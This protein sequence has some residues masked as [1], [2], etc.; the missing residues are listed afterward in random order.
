[1]S[2]RNSLVEILVVEIPVVEIPVV[3]ISHSRAMV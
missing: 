1:M 2:D 3:E